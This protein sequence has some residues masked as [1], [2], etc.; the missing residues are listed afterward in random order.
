MGPRA[1]AHGDKSTS[2]RV[3]RTIRRFNGAAGFRPRRLH[4]R[5][6][7]RTLPIQLQWG[8]GLSP[9]ET[10]AKRMVHREPDALQ[11]GRGLSPTETI[12]KAGSDSTSAV[13]QWGRGLSPTETSP[14]SW[15]KARPRSGFN[16]AA[17]FRPRRLAGR[18]RSLPWQLW[19]QWGRGLSPTETPPAV[20]D[21]YAV[22]RLQWGRGLS[23]TE[24]ADV[25]EAWEHYRKASM[26]PRAFA[27]GDPG[28]T[29]NGYRAEITL[30]WGRGLSPTETRLTWPSTFSRST[31]FNG[32][33]G[34]RP[35]RPAR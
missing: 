30:Q 12:L 10:P 28:N 34:F 33:A 15:R 2:C 29:I 35:R 22:S 13:L 16:G 6:P 32:A 21:A 20:K 5:P 24:T 17:G 19:L 9:T 4:R 7:I 18:A 11:W 26:G 14:R 25:K 23:P 3:T 8:R 31:G 1:F 27:H